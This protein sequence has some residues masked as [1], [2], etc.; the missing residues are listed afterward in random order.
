MAK[1]NQRLETNNIDLQNIL[2]TINALPEAGVQLPALDN[3]GAAADIL[4]GKQFINQEGEIVE[5]TMPNNGAI[6]QTMDGINIKS[7]AIPS[8]YTSGGMISLD[9]TI[10]NEVDEQTDLIAQIAA[11]VDGLPEVGSGGEGNKM[12]SIT[13]IGTDYVYYFDENNHLQANNGGTFLA[14]NG[15]VFISSNGVYSL[16]AN[17]EYESSYLHAFNYCIFTTNGGTIQRGSMG[18]E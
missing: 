14:L 16:V 6:S 4:S 17:G 13:N 18:G 8:G 9:N 11:A 15:I 10:G 5:G 2:D 12:I 7:V 1:F 3:E